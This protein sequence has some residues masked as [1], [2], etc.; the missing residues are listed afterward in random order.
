MAAHRRLSIVLERM[1][2]VLNRT[3]GDSA[4]PGATGT[5]RLHAELASL[6][7]W[8]T[9]YLG[10]PA[11]FALEE[12]RRTA[13][14]LVRSI[15][16]Q[17]ALP[18]PNGSRDEIAGLGADTAEL[19]A[20]VDELIQ[21][22]RDSK[23]T[24]AEFRAAGAEVSRIIVEGSGNLA[25]DDLR[26]AHRYV[27]E[28]SATTFATVGA[29]GVGALLCAI[30]AVIVISRGVVRPVRALSVGTAR[31]SDGDLRHRIEVRGTDELGTL[32][33][34]FNRM[35]E[36]LA[37][38]QSR[39]EEANRGLEAEVWARTQ[40]LEVTNHRLRTM[41][42]M[43]RDAAKSLRE[44]K[45]A[46][47]L[48]SRSKS[49]FLAN[50]SH[51]LRTPLNAIIGFSDIMRAQV[52]GPLGNA[53]YSEYASDINE[54]GGHLLSLIN[55]ILDLSKIEANKYELQETPFDLV[56][57]IE[58]CIRL[59]TPRAESKG[60]ALDIRL[61]HALP[62]FLADERALKQ[63]L[64]NLLTN[65]IK[66]TPE[67]GRVETRAELEGDGSLVLSV[68]DTGIGIAKEDLARVR[69]P[70]VQANDPAARQIEGTGLGLA[71]TDRLARLHGGTLEIESELGR[72]TK[73]SLR[74]P[75]ARMG[76]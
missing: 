19:M 35:A 61:W 49:Q 52:F 40:E 44:A 63:M 20:V 75:G 3:D 32:A 66:F 13:N 70:F 36:R 72:G 5:T 51:E 60:V 45:E 24:F 37:V 53:H 74:F 21:L 76:A 62:P 47:E 23:A 42:E 54:S 4:A 64:L 55:D 33:A 73:V 17:G 8:I 18:G 25:R 39:L 38:A 15:E 69:E 48:A 9:N 16:A 28:R 65:A 27:S 59:V 22:D 68:A 7:L 1:D 26:E 31:L 12:L 43:H 30:L 29:L 2:A 57:V 34:A 71:L 14:R 11:P 6:A 56:R 67:G 58:R 46:A 10:A 41:V 50:M